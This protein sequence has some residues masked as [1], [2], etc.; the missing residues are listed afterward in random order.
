MRRLH[1]LHLLLAVSLSFALA[2][3]SLAAVAV[4]IK[5]AKLP[6][7]LAARKGTRIYTPGEADTTPPADSTGTSAK[8]SDADPNSLEGCM[9]IWDKGTHITRSKWSEICRRQIKERQAEQQQ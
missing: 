1:P 9:A 8:T 6:V 2:G 4:A 7:E 3:P 5:G